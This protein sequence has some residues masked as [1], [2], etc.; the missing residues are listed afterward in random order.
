MFRR[1]IL[2]KIHGGT[3]SGVNKDYEGSIE[4]SSDLYERAGMHAGEVVSVF[5][6]DNGERFETYIIPGERDSGEI[7]INGAAARK[8]VPGDKVIV[9]TYCYTDTDPPHPKV[10]VLGKNNTVLDDR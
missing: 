10:I 9:L 6:I 3:V 1:F 4:I 8:A 5:N 7:N 2:G